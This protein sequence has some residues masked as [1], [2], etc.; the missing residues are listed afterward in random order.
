MASNFV[1]VSFIARPNC[2]LS[3]KGKFSVVASIALLSLVIAI[4]FTMAGAWL[5]LPFAG[6]ELI[7][8]AYAFYFIHLHAQDYESIVINETHLAIETHDIH[9]HRQIVMQRYWA[10]VQLRNRPHG[11]Q[12]LFVRSHGKEVELGRRFMSNEQRLQLAHQLQQAIQ[13]GR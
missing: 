10:Q 7:A 6:L 4:V 5:V 3:L 9:T 2:A 8:V 13:D 11:E 12:A 1:E